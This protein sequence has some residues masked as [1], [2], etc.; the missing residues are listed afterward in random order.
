MLDLA[1]QNILKSKSGL[2][3]DEALLR[4]FWHEDWQQ[5]PLIQ[6]L[7]RIFLPPDF[8]L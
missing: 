8:H 3:F 6:F 1:G 4:S 5:R 7:P 2:F